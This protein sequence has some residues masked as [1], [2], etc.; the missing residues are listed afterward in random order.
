MASRG[1]RSQTRGA[2]ARAT[3][4]RARAPPRRERQPPDLRA[5]PLRPLIERPTLAAA[6]LLALP[7]LLYLWPVLLGGRMLTPIPVLYLFVPWSHGAPA[8]YHDWFNLDLVDPALADYPWRAFARGLIRDGILPAWN[9]HVFAGTP[10]FSN[11]QT[12]IFSLFSLPLWILPLNYGIGVGAALKLWVGAFGCYL[13]VRQLRLGFLPGLLAGVAFAFSS[14]NIVWLTHETLPAVAVLLP[15]MVL[16]VERIFE[17]ARPL[18][19]V[20]LALATAIGLGGGHPGMQVHLLAAVALYAALRV[21]FG[22][23][24]PAAW[25]RPLALVAGGLLVGTLLMGVMLI[26]ELLSSQGT[27]GT[28]ARRGGRGTLPGTVMP[29]DAI[30]TTLLPDW[31]GRASGYEAQNIP[32][33]SAGALVNFNERTFY[34]GV[35]AL[36]LALV[37]LLEREGWRRKA[38]FLIL[39]AIGL[40]IPLHAPG[41]YWLATH[42]PVF[43]DV[44]SQRM[45]FIFAFAFA[46]LAAFGLR[47]V[48]D[49]PAERRW[50]LVP[51]AVLFVGV[52]ALAS[53]GTQPGDAGRVVRHF[54]SGNDYPQSGVLALTSV[55]WLLLLAGGVGLALLAGWRWR[56]HAALVATALVA[57]AVLDALHFAHGLQPMGPE[58]RAFPPRTPAI[59]YLQRHSAEGRVAG[60]ELA[61]GHA[62]AAVRYGLDDVRGYEPPQPSL[63]FF[64]LWQRANPQQVDWRPLTIET[65]SPAT[66]RVLSLLGGRYVVAPPGARAAKTADFS[67]VYHGRDATIFRLAGTMPRAMIAPTVVPAANEAAARAKLLEPDLDPRTAVVVTR[68]QPGADAAIAASPGAHGHVA[69]VDE[70]NASVT[71]RATLDRPGLIV[72]DDDFARGWSVRIDGRGAQA[73]RVDETLRGVVV[74]R[75]RHEIRW[76][77]AV[78]GLRA[79]LAL[80]LLALALLVGVAAWDRRRAPSGD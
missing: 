23:D 15:W 11:P 71:L 27:L 6:L 57:L 34:A 40:A 19:A 2:P 41:L 1:G 21:A 63:R 18:D 24:P 49:R 59:A 39:G 47:A 26:P 54:L 28:V 64:H 61:L 29:F 42:L 51:A 35:V 73:L 31:W 44:Q 9:P 52:L 55:V 20:G 76:S 46:I 30:K 16:F 8:S 22:D 37:G 70:A 56:R 80:S 78:P 17:R 65:L 38:P 50:A 43:E 7:V 69:V 53:A 4:P 12:G 75:G 36:L 58:S 25:R 62:W 33:T 67:R 45:H 13:L 68:D 10:F 32:P 74:G 3:P 79:G 66:T 14:L 48:L 72:L 5:T 60:L 77:Y